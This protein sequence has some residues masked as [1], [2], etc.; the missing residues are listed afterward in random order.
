MYSESSAKV[1]FVIR[2]LNIGGAER[3]LIEL[4][5]GL[6]RAGWNVTVATFYGGGALE[7]MLA[8]QGVRHI[9]LGKSGRWDVVR[10]MYRL[11]KLI[12]AERPQIIYS[13]LTMSNVLVGLLA[14]LVRPARVVWGVATSNMDLSYYDWLAKAEVALEVRLANRAEL[15]ICNSFAG[16]NCHVA[17]GYPDARTV[18]VCNGI[19]TE[20]FQPDPVARR[21]IRAEW[22]IARDEKL[23]GIVG[24]LDPI[25]DHCNFL[26]AA[27]V[28]A[29]VYPNAR[30]A[31]V[32]EGMPEYR[33]QL[34][35]LAEE[36]GIAARV[37]WVTERTDIWRVYNA[38]D[39][40]VSSSISEG[41]TNVVAE[42]MATDVRCVA[43]AVGDS[44]RLVNNPRWLAPPCDSGALAG[45][46][47]NGLVDTPEPPGVLRSRIVGEYSVR[48][49]A[50]HTIE[51]FGR[52]LGT[53]VPSGR[54]SPAAVARP[55]S[56]SIVLLTRRL[57]VGGAQ[58]QLIELAKGLHD[59]GWSVRV[60]TFYDGGALLDQLETAGVPVVSLGKS[61]RW[62]ILGFL[63]R[64]VTLV[65]AEQ[66]HVVH[67][68][69]DMSNVLLTLLRPFLGSVR[70]VWGVRASNMNLMDYDRLAA[71]ESRLG[72]ALARYADLI[73][74]NSEAGR[75][76]HVTQG[77]P[78][79][80]M[81]VIPNGVDAARFAPD[82]EARE[83][84][85]REW[86]VAA[87]ERLVGV[88]AR[89]DPMKDHRNFLHAAA[90]VAA[91]HANARFVCIG[92]GPA[93]YRSALAHEARSLGLER[94][95]IWAGARGDMPR[96]YNA[97]DLAV[98][99]SAYGEGFPNTIVEAMASGVPCVVTDVGDSAAIV[100]TL[101]WVCVPSDSAALAAAIARALDALPC[102]PVRVREHVMS[103]YS[104]AIL[105]ER[106]S[107]QLAPLTARGVAIAG[108]PVGGS[109]E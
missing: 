77:Y 50:E 88:V 12:R 8:A 70:V 56:P 81:V 28:V 101:G 53:A 4:A 46:I 71:L 11:V 108:A 84:V 82:A 34:V 13:M 39:L 10:F 109:N 95:L 67:G 91:T 69:L 51:H 90:R 83:A 25:K 40:L 92:D 15:I 52:V 57:D 104:S 3:Q 27:K 32:G 55:S 74:C 106:T 49:L 44:A 59:A 94:T 93:Q 78:A 35:A 63:W 42:A 41:L 31:C 86:G 24:R 6:K 45:A 99:S 43:T 102:N 62:D 76:Y 1:L 100:G 19:D 97:L 48:R 60:A 64:L 37:L 36:L 22:A 73:I 96:V 66:P 54:R 20:K 16:R 33:R 5:A 87:E 38:L 2:S 9:S 30:F 58:R 7:P 107:A 80:R 79:K 47:V 72:R 68:Y 61:G 17:R 85:R 105:L 18:V 14:P 75:A 26:R 98:S 65:R 29:R 23:I 21:E 89:L 103:A